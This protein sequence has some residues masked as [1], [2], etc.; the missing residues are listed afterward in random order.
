M[1]ENREDKITVKTDTQP[2][3]MS[4]SECAVLVVD[5]QNAFLKKGGYFD[6]ADIDISGPQAII[7][8]CRKI[9]ETARKRGVRIIYL[10][11][12]YSPD[13]TDKG[14]P[15]SP[16]ALKARVPVLLKQRPE[17]KEKLYIYGTWG[18][19]IIDELRPQKGDIIIKKQRYDGFMGTNL[20]ITLRTLGIKLSLIHI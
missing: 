10:Q 3:D 20:D 11:M 13:L 17:L 18:A 9:I 16:Y 7:K 6:V 12:G 1:A 4:L 5:M 14:P 8:P 15:G 2:L 19:E